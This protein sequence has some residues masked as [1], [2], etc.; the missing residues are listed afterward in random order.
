MSMSRTVSAILAVVLGLN[1]L[2]MLAGSWWWYNHVPGVTATGAFN[3]HFIRDIGATYL[4]VT[5]GLAWFAW[6]PA[7]GWPALAAAA[8][9]LVLHAGIHIFD[10]SCS[11]TGWADVIRDFPGVYLPAIL[12]GAIA[13]LNLPKT[14]EP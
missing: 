14:K 5:L 2:A 9:F 10:A 6:R 8:L 13:G 3:W 4:T 1:G 11:K 12:A 7:Q